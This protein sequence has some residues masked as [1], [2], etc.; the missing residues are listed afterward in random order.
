MYT[1]DIQ[2]DKILLQIHSL[3]RKD[4]IMNEVAKVVSISDNLAEMFAEVKKLDSQHIVWK[5]KTRMKQFKLLP[6]SKQKAVK[7]NQLKK[8]VEACNKLKGEFDLSQILDKAV[9][10]GLKFNKGG[11]PIKNIRYY[12]SF[13]QKALIIKAI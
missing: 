12:S 2:R 8:Y 9:E 5:D 4:I 11:D 3:I 10:Q 7:G 6:K 1:F 13:L